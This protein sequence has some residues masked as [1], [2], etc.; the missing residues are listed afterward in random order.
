MSDARTIEGHDDPARDEWITVHL[1]ELPLVLQQRASEH[2]EELRREIT[3]VAMSRDDG[4]P[5]PRRLTEV[6]DAISARY[7]GVSELPDA[8]RAAAVAAGHDTIDLDF[9]VPPSVADA[10]RELM[11][12][13]ADAD[14]YCREG[15]HLLT[16][17]TPRELVVFREWYL[18]EF[19]AQTEGGSN[20]TP[21]PHYAGTH[22]DK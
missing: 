22:L 13:L 3:L 11:D 6:V 21:W 12:L 14:A 10:S 17:E 19:I 5:L 9:S 2:F 7:A 16:L 20:P 1:I 18:G 8:Q 15:E 4:H